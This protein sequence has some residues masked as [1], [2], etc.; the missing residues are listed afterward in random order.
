MGGWFIDIFVEYLFRMATRVVKMRGSSAWH[1]AKATVTSSACPKA[2]YGCTVA[3]VHYAY[4][5]HGELYTGTN[6]KSFI[7]PNSGENYVSH[8]TPG[9]EFTVRVKPNNPEVHIVREGDQR[10][11]SI[12]SGQTTG[13]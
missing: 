10:G 1:V 12:P 9:K 13:V 6:E 4:R 5:V 8:F 3:E 7:S 2:A 11:S